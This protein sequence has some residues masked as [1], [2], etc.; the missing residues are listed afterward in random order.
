[1]RRLKGR[2]ARPLLLGAA[3]TILIVVTSF[4]LI[5]ISESL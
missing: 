1:L 3:G 5:L 2:G 4:V